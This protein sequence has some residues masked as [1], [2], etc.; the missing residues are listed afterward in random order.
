M[1]FRSLVNRI[2]SAASSVFVYLAAASAIIP[3]IAVALAALQPPGSITTGFSWPSDPHWENFANAWTVAGFNY[4]FR[5]SAIVALVIVPVGATFAT[6]AG[7]ALGTI[8]FKG[9]GALMALFLVGLTVPYEAIVIP[10]YYGFR[11]VGLLDTHLALILPL[12]GAFMPFGIFWMRNHFQSL[13]ESLGEAAQMDGANSWQ[14]FRRIMLPTARPAI[15][16]LALLYFMWAWNQ[17]LLALILIQDATMRTAPAGLGQFI[18]QYGKDVPLLSAATLLVV[19][20]IVVVYLFF[21]RQF[22]QG[23]LQGAVK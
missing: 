8:K 9:N 14:T 23:I 4:L 17:F 22:V 5:N 6:L 11:G 18:T 15:S 20:P 16:T 2:N 13:P 7:Y 21:Q 1:L 19:V 10:L 3:F 12:A